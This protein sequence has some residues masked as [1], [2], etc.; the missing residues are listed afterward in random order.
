MVDSTPVKNPIKPTFL[1]GFV[2]FL[3]LLWDDTTIYG[4][5]C[6]FRTRE[7]ASVSSDESQ[8]LHLGQSVGPFF[9]GRR[10]LGLPRGGPVLAWRHAT[11]WANL[12]YL[13][14]S[15][16]I[17]VKKYKQVLQTTSRIKS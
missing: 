14:D 3:P 12:K 7:I 9:L 10:C 15:L 13:A 8:F 6:Y 11:S 1:C 5:V 17:S 2:A 16:P 4:C